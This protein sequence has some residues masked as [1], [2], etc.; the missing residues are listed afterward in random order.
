MYI[1]NIPTKYKDYHELDEQELDDYTRELINRR[2]ET[3]AAYLKCKENMKW[4]WQ[5]R[6]QPSF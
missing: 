3:L 2:L 1:F 4:E 5:L 6:E